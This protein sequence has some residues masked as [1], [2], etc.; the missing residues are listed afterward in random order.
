[1]ATTFDSFAQTNWPVTLVT[2]G[3]S[4]IYSQGETDTAFMCTFAPRQEENSLDVTWEVAARQVEIYAA[5]S[6]V[7][8]ACN[9]REDKITVESVTY[10]VLERGSGNNAIV[11]FLCERV[12]LQ[13]VAHR[14]R[15][16]R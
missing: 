7:P 10:T 12:D 9:P 11:R 13:S 8:T 3:T 4:A 6:D 2:F 5:A 15:M 14:G 16:R 1:M